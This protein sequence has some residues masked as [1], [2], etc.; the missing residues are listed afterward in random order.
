MTRKEVDAGSVCLRMGLDPLYK[1]TEELCFLGT[2]TLML[3]PFL[4]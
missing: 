3:S 4:T 2:D 1:I